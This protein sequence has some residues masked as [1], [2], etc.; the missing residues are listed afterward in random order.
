M[1]S[2]GTTYNERVGLVDAFDECKEL[3]SQKHFELLIHSA[4]GKTREGAGKLKYI[5]ALARRCKSGVVP[6]SVLAEKIE[7]EYPASPVPQE[8]GGG[9]GDEDVDVDMDIETDAGEYENEG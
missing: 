3:F 4:L 9:E 2:S 5:L 8:Q 7:E 6:A 1:P